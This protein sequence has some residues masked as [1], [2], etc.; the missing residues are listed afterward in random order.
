MLPIEVVLSKS[1][2][3]KLDLAA[4]AA[5]RGHAS[6][7]FGLDA[8]TGVRVVGVELW[9]ETWRLRK[10]AGLGL[11]WAGGIKYSPNPGIHWVLGAIGKLEG[12]D[13][14]ALDDED[15]AD[16]ETDDVFDT[17]LAQAQGSVTA[18]DGL[19][20][21]TALPFDWRKPIEIYPATLSIPN[22]DDPHE[23]SRDAG[24]TTVRFTQGSRSVFER[25]GVSR[26]NWPF[27]GKR[28]QF[29]PHEER[30]E[31]EKNR[32]RTLLDT[33]GFDRSGTD[34]DHVHELQFGGADTFSNL[35]PADNS[36]NRSAGR[37]H[38]DQ[39]ENY[40][41]QIGNL[42]GRHFVITRVGI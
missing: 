35:W 18:P 2:L 23:L 20:P 4:E 38:A 7:A 24:P 5:L 28:F 30:E 14:L 17:L 6:L 25:I 1:S 22:A 42:A 26:G 32:L 41:Q 36:A 10:E 29:I 39:L 21:R 16:V 33:L 37:R 15:E 9:R 13:D 11:G 12:I 40:R 19:S 31:P 27:Q 3:D 34:V 8:T